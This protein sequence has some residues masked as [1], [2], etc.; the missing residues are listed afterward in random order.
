MSNIT[1]REFLKRN[2]NAFPILFDDIDSLIQ[3]AQAQ[4]GNISVAQDKKRVYVEAALPGVEP[5]DIEVTHDRGSLWIKGK[6]RE[7][8]SQ[9]KS[10]VRKATQKFSYKISFPADIQYEVE[11]DVMLKNGI[12]AMAFPKADASV[13]RSSKNI[14]RKMSSSKQ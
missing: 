12:I 7:D 13:D 8:K 1:S 10:Y 14:H 11:P 2:S 9:E 3:E 6:T 5:D 4:S